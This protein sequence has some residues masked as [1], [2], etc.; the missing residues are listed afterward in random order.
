MLPAVAQGA[1]GVEIRRRDGRMRAW[2]AAV[3]DAASAMA[4]AAE[5]AFLAVLDGSCKTPIAALAEIEGGRLTLR[6][7]I[8]SPD[9]T[10]SF[11][12]RRCGDGADA[13][14]LGADAGAELRLRAGPGFFDFPLAVARP[15]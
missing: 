2:L 11:E 14:R 1:I 13:A 8:Y 6:C 3:N 15:L 12:T 4:L 10:T 5:R 7:G 9:G